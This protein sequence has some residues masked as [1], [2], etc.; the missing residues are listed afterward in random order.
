M[1]KLF[2]FLISLS[3]QLF[4]FNS[5]VFASNCTTKDVVLN[6]NNNLRVYASKLVADSDYAIYLSGTFNNGPA[7]DRYVAGDFIESGPDAQIDA[8][9]TI[10]NI[11][12]KEGNKYSLALKSTSGDRCDVASFTYSTAGTPATSTTCEITSVKSANVSS[13]DIRMGS[14]V[15]ISANK[16]NSGG[17]YLVLIDDHATTENVAVPAGTSTYTATVNLPNKVVISGGFSYVSPGKHTI[18]LQNSTDINE[19]CSISNIEL[20][21]S[22]L[23]SCSASSFPSTDAG[24]MSVNIQGSNLYPN[25]NHEIKFDGS[26][27]NFAKSNSSG[28]I[29]HTFDVTSGGI[30]KVSLVPAEGTTAGFYECV[31]PQPL[32]ISLAPTAVPLPIVSP[33]PYTGP[34]IGTGCSSGGG[35]P[36]DVGRG[37]AFKTAIGCV[38]TNP[39]E[40]VKDFSTFAIA[41]S[42]GLAFLLMLLGAFQMLRSA[43]NPEALQAGRDRLTSA[44]IGLLFVIFATLLL[45][46]IGIDILKIPGFTK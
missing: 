44:I 39:V 41:V 32:T 2:I 5:S 4:L 43:G 1:V 3:L 7:N 29:N 12:L 23:N 21:A 22:Q 24:A 34:C 37:P 9:I 14:P 42:G 36:C 16:L 18:T 46:V 35:Q 31:V 10:P 28:V 13:S 38:H 19:R 15:L 26:R 8:T 33:T 45:Q 30:V 11:G 40:F 17:T 25:T 20:K 27:V 6:P